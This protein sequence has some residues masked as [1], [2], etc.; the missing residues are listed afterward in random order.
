MKYLYSPCSNT[1]AFFLICSEVGDVVIMD[2]K[3]WI[4]KPLVFLLFLLYACEPRPNFN[5]VLTGF[6]GSKCYCCWGPK[7]KLTSR[8]DTLIIDE[9]PAGI[10]IDSNT[11]YP[12]YVEV[13][14]KPDSTCKNKIDITYLEFK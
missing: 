3:P 11:Q 12:V 13:D 5:A 10:T 8:T 1:G 14:W 9:L 6:E 2:S 7:I 4:M